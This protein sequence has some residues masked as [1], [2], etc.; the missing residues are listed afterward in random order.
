MLNKS[1]SRKRTS[2]CIFVAYICLW[3]GFALAEEHRAH[4][5]RLQPGDVIGFS[6]IGYPDMQKRAVVDQSGTVVLPVLGPLDVL[7]KTIGD[8]RRQ[9]IDGLKPKALPQRS[10]D[11]V[12]EN[13]AGFYPDQIVVD[14]EEY[15]PVYVDGDIA[16]P[17]SLTFRPG[18]TIR[19]A[20]ASAGG[21][22]IGT[23]ANPELIVADLNGRLNVLR[24]KHQESE[25][26]VARIRA[27]LSG[28]KGFTA[29]E[30]TDPALIS[31]RT[32]ALQ[33]E[34]N[35]LDALNLDHRKERASIELAIAKAA[36]RME[37][38]HEQ[39]K[40]DQKGADAD[41][42]E[43]A[44]VKGLFDKGLVQI[45]TLNAA[46]RAVL[47][48]ATRAL[49]TSSEIAQLEREQGTLQR[50]LEKLG[51]QSRIDLLAELQTETAAIT[52]MQAEMDGL[53]KQISYVGLLRS[54]LLT[55]QG[56]Q[57]AI[58]VT[59]F[60]DGKMTTTAATEDMLLA[61]GDTVSVKLQV[62]SGTA[63]A[64]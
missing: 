50:S 54:D 42:K 49:Q 62:Q 53:T 63:A 58:S 56:R 1:M 37:Y 16:S 5:Y 17:G 38:L 36:K 28:D 47:L 61:P 39:Q 64:N 26:K 57:L 45:T 19:Q 11:G 33:L 14:I 52:Q 32:E 46:Q 35:R 4:E 23:V 48:S 25:I 30:E 22:Q 18:M 8:V 12:S 44:R 27:Q 10:S 13:W 34:Q 3:N 41:D 59:R 9:V 55:Q 15:R 31:R 40:T 29:A 51:D 2:S 60:S 21:Y 43:V 7:Q 24:A 6:V 20:V